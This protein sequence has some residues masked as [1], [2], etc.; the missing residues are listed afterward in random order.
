MHES[1]KSFQ[2]DRLK[3]HIFADKSTLGHAAGVQAALQMR[4][5]LREQDRIRIVL[6]AAPSQNEFLAALVTMEG[7][8]WT[9]VVV[10]QMDEYVGLDADDPRSFRSFLESR[11]CV[12]VKPGEVH[13]IDPGHDR[14][15]QWVR[16][17]EL[18]G[19]AP[20]NL[21]CLGI[22][23]NGHIAFNDPG[24]ADFDDPQ[25]IKQV[26][27]DETSRRQQV[28]DG[29]FARLESV[30]KMAVTLT[31]PVLL[32][33]QQLLCMVSGANKRNAVRR[34]LYGPLSPQCPASILRT[35]PDCTLLVDRDAVDDCKS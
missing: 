12:R 19:Q 4:K 32:G 8:D 35:H 14:T 29:C 5:M 18:V 27:L 33:G 1:I 30:P 23:E 7:I 16:Y 6:A 13:F 20:I 10:F 9:R 22:G 11:L 3:V 25:I 21:V 31:V 34:T 17:G 15:T 28:H 24:I 26:A 2:I